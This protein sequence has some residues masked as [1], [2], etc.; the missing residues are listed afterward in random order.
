[1]ERSPDVSDNARNC[2]AWFSERP[3]NQAHSPDDSAVHDGGLLTNLNGAYDSGIRCNVGQQMDRRVPA[4]RTNPGT[5]TERCFVEALVSTDRL[6]ASKMIPW[7]GALHWLGADEPG[8]H[9][10][11]QL[12]R[13]K[14]NCGRAAVWGS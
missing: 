1:M 9:I 14:T 11:E 7:L 2:C 4:S 8:L 12:Y 5:G 10:S 13:Q 3:R 6:D